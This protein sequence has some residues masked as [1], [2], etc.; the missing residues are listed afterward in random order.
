M[1]KKTTK[2]KEVIDNL[3]NFNFLEKKLIFSKIIQN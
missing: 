3:I 1:A 2:Q